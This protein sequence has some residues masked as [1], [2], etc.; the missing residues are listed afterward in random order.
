MY[1]HLTGVSLAMYKNFGSAGI[2]LWHN[3]KESERKIPQQ[4]STDVH[5][6]VGVYIFSLLFWP[7]DP[8]ISLN[9][10]RED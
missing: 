2:N 5:S 8:F 10:T 6:Y 3:Q 9:I 1:N 4:S 7:L